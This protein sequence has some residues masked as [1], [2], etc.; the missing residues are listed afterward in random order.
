MGSIYASLDPQVS[1]INLA[2]V[3]RVIVAYAV[4]EN[5]LLP[6]ANAYCEPGCRRGAVLFEEMT[7]YSRQA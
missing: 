1:A 7:L 3:D 4:D 2:G 5:K 6:C